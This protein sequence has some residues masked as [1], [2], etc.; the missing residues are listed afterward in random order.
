MTGAI[1]KDSIRPDFA[2]T[3]YLGLPFRDGGRGP[4]AYDCWGLVKAVY[5]DFG[6]EVKDYI[7]SC[8]DTLAI[9]DAMTDRSSGC[10]VKIDEPMPP[11]VVTMRID[12]RHPGLVNHVG[13]YIGCGRYLQALEKTGVVITRLDDIKFKRC[14]EGFYRW[15]G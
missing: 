7:V 11:C 8:W 4:D 9:S 10:W 6:L 15:N 1:Y 12:V 2:V 13:I 14:I 3:N 5:R